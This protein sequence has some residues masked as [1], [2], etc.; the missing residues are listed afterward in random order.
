MFG[1]V[2]RKA[3]LPLGLEAYS[4]SHDQMNFFH[5]KV[6]NATSPINHS[7]TILD[8][9]ETNNLIHVITD[10]GA[11]VL[12]CLCGDNIWQIECYPPKLNTCCLVLE[13]DTTHYCKAKIIQI[14]KSWYYC[15]MLC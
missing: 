15:S 12:E 4:Y 3:N 13:K 11:E 7:S 10:N 1:L 6:A 5:S 2:Q 9:R 14:N 8:V